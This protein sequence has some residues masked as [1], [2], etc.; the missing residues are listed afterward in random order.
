MPVV[1]VVEVLWLH[2]LPGSSLH[3]DVD[4]VTGEAVFI[5]VDQWPATSTP[6]AHEHEIVELTPANATWCILS[7]EI[8]AGVM[9][10]DG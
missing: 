4:V 3:I 10:G 7:A 5:E 2:V 1:F 6:T 8:A 9:G